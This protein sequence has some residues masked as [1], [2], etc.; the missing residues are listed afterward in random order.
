MKKPTKHSP[1]VAGPAANEPEATTP[2]RPNDTS[3]QQKH[4][5]QNLESG[6]RTL[7]KDSSGDRTQK[8]PTPANAK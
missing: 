4:E 3:R 6:S 7:D 8:G 1:L 2:G 5:D